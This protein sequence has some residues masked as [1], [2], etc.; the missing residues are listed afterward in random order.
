MDLWLFAL[1]A[2]L[3][4]PVVRVFMAAGC[5]PAD[6]PPGDR[7]LDVTVTKNEEIPGGGRVS[8]TILSGAV[9][10]YS[11]TGRPSIDRAFGEGGLPLEEFPVAP[12]A[13]DG[14]SPPYEW[15]AE[16]TV[17]YEVTEPIS[18]RT[19]GTVRGGYPEGAGTWTW[20]GNLNGW[21]IF[22][23]RLVDL[24]VEGDVGPTP[25]GPPTPDDPTRGRRLVWRL[26]GTFGAS[27]TT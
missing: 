19:R 22:T 5:R 17:D 8:V 23:L 24:G 11:P 12:A 18:M 4:I 21:L 13:F 16:C 9:H 20:D 27:G 6:P 2:L 25:G 7:P 15:S 1:I 26:P 10:V 3:L 14:A